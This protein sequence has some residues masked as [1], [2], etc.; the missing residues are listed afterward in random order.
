VTA[1][2]EDEDVD[3]LDVDMDPMEADRA[4][5]RKATVIYALWT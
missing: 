3:S 1:I 4:P 2:L 5:L